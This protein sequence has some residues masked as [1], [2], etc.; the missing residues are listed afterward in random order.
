MINNFGPISA[1]N[2]HM[3]HGGDYNP[4]QWLHM[5]HVLTDDLRLMKLAGCNAMSVGIFAWAALEP[6]DGEYTF[7]WMDSILDRLYENGVYTIL[8]TPSGARPAWMAQKYPDV[9]RV[10]PNRQRNLFGRRHNHCYTS[11]E[12]RRKVLAMNTRL[13]ERYGSHPGVLLWHLSNEYGGECHCELCQEAFR[14]W[15]KS[16]YSNDLDDLNRKWWGEFWSHSYTDWSQ[17][18]SP[19]P[20]GEGAV[21]AH[22]LDWRRFVTDQTVDFMRAEIA[23]L[24]AVNPELPVTTNLM[25]TY[26][27]LNYWKLA[28]YLDIVSWD[29]YPS[30][31]GS[32]EISNPRGNWDA[33]GRDW[34]LASDIAFAH[35]LNRSLKGG[36]PFML[37][38]STPSMTN[39]QDVSKKKRPGMHALSSLQAIAHGSDTVQYFQWRKSRGSSEKFHGAV[40]DH[41]GHEN[42]RV[43]GDVKEVGE[44][45]S[46]LDE[47]VGTGIEARAAVIFDW[48]NR[49][50]MD[51]AQGPRNTGGSTYERICKDHYY[52]LWRRGIAADVVDMDADLSGYK[53]VIAPMLYMVRE[54]VGQRVPEFVAKGG[55][56]VATYWSG[57]VDESD[58]C[59][60]GGFPGPLREV[61]GIWSE[62]ID[63]LYPGETNSVV[64]VDG[65]PLGLVSEYEA[66]ELCDLI[67]TEEATVLAVYGADFYK[68]RPALTVN[69]F[70]KG[71]AY[72]VASRNSEEFLDDLYGSVCNEIDLTGPLDSEP[73]EGVSVSCR[74]DQTNEFV[75]VMNFKPDALVVNVG[76]GDFV[77]LLTG[78]NVGPAVELDPYGVAVLKRL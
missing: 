62:E 72:Y 39:W 24:K 56:F 3:L 52:Q 35:D 1:K 75:F 22:N 50:A 5:P 65:N 76:E 64:P 9:L 78:R 23:P 17:I 10:G 25:G 27:T 74:Q 36:K 11:P 28:P 47:V 6:Q 54:G 67:H 21:H 66:R 12:Y 53:L 16:R 19:A 69:E 37:M 33:E 44:L 57:I 60:L 45:L 2:P 14:G 73:P 32:G 38:E 13:A 61:L 20:H 48:E 71:K 51:D 59:F 55:R 63:A 49:W 34:R 46:R 42:T 43:F 31:H 68:G 18:Q 77:D 7:D 30:W 29:S 70:G 58:L 15:L 8:A 26:Y 41:V 40:V 4:D